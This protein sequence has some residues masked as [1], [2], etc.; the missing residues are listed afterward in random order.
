MAVIWRSGPPVGLGFI[1]PGSFLSGL[2]LIFPKSPNS[3]FPKS[4]T[5]FNQFQVSIPEEDIP[6]VM[7]DKEKRVLSIQSTVVHGYAGGRSAVFPLQ[8]HGFVT[9]STFVLSKLWRKSTRFT[10]FYFQIIRVDGPSEFHLNL[11]DMANG[12]DL[13]QQQSKY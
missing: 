9:S 3:K 4:F 8:L 2:C 6:Q 7:T 10:R 1:W 5:S 13:K 11:Q 12:E